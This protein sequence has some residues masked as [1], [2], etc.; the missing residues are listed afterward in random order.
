MGVSSKV[1]LLGHYIRQPE[2]DQDPYGG[3]FDSEDDSE[4][5]EYDPDLGLEGYDEDEDE[6][7][8]EEDDDDDEDAGPRIQE[9]TSEAEAGPSKA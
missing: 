2:L 8:D 7:F 3:E 4:M 9:I 5:G 1:H 6:D